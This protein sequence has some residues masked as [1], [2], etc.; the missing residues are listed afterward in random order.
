MIK[1]SAFSCQRNLF[2]EE[3]FSE[4]GLIQ[5]QSGRTTP[6]INAG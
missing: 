4:T 6:N 1:A 2:G 3:N 5:Q